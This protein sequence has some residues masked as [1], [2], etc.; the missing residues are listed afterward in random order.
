MFEE[1]NHYAK[2]GGGFGFE[3]TLSGRSYRGLIRR[4]NR[5]GYGVHLFFLWVPTVDLA[6]A[7]VGQRVVEG[8]HDVTES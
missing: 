7:R 1:I 5:C 3:T 8:G 4:L 2:H 6:L